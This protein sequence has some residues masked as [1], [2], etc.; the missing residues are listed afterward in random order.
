MEK[1]NKCAG[2]GLEKLELRKGGVKRASTAK[3]RQ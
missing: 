2:K 1:L 3:R